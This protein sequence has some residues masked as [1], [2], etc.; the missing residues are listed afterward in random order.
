MDAHRPS[1]GLWRSRITGRRCVAIFESVPY[2]KG[3]I[4]GASAVKDFTQTDI[5]PPSERL[6][7]LT[8]DSRK[9]LAHRAG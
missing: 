8:D 3:N 7:R 4:T 9:T 1:S 6:T 2:R 5:G